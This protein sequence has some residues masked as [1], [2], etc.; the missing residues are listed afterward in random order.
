MSVK[1]LVSVILPKR[2]GEDVSKFISAIENS[3]YMNGF[4]FDVE[5]IV[6]NLGQER[7]SQ[8]NTGLE[9]MKGNYVLVL[10]SDQMVTPDLIGECVFLMDKNPDCTGIY[11]PEI[12]PG[13][14]WFSRLRNWERQFYNGTAVDVVRFVRAKDCP[15][16]DLTMSGPEDADWGNRIQGKKLISKNYFYHYD[17]VSL[18]K[19]LQKKAYYSKSMKKYQEKWPQDK[20]LNFWYRCFWVFFERGKWKRFLGNP[21]M[22]LGVMGIIFL[23]G[24]IYLC[25]R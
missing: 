20:C 4:E 9:T 6:V 5:I 13:N 19:Y 12:I 23:R 25:K 21:V 24:V 18:K 10:D 2:K 14:D 8:R 3:T 22:A 15:K 11:I 16:F 7:S 17:N 1:N